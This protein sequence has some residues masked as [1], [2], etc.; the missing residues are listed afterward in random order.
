MLWNIK[1]GP[2]EAKKLFF[3][4]LAPMSSYYVL[5][6]KRCHISTGLSLEITK[7]NISIEKVCPA[8]DEDGGGGV[9]GPAADEWKVTSFWILSFFITM[10]SSR[11][12][13]RLFTPLPSNAAASPPRN[14][15]QGHPEIGGGP[16]GPTW[17][18]GSGFGEEQSH[19]LGPQRQDRPEILGRPEGPTRPEGLLSS[20]RR[21]G[22]SGQG[23]IGSRDG[24]EG[25]G[26]DR[27]WQQ[28][29]NTN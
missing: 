18:E 3:E 9:R 14:S 20:C 15:R 4:I 1:L 17:P 2:Q 16:E 12:S 21:G 5:R 19:P 28:H 29:Y 24:S 10:P 11:P 25:Q 23:R 8:A 27:S 7:F 22:G 13:A 6:H 26:R